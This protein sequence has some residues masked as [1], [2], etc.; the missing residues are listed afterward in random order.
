MK[1]ITHQTPYEP[2]HGRIKFVTE[3]VNLRDIKNKKILDIGCGYGWFEIYAKNNLA[4]SIV[5]T[6]LTEDDLST[7][8][9]YIREKKII[10]VK[11]SAI[12][13]PFKD[14]SF[15]TVVTWEVMEH[16]PKGTEE[17]MFMEIARVLKKGGIC[18]LSTPNKSFIGTLFDP[19]YWLIG[20]RH[21][22]KKYIRE[23][24]SKTR[25]TLHDMR[26][27]GGWWEIISLLDLYISK[28]IFQ[29]VPFFEKAI[30]NKLDRE[31]KKSSGFTNIFCR[32]QKV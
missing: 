13:L 23:L 6:E 31:Y 2:L 15:D 20:H 28:W 24:T 5:G 8:K 3:Y 4:S 32:M 9:K 14:N 27:M 7:A 12:A 18:Y 1:N 26:V 16:T 21:Y 19:A 25:F 11:G 30:T 17:K 22:S 10:F 29:R